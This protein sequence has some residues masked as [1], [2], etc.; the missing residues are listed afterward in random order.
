MTAP[1]SLKKHKIIHKLVHVEDV[2]DLLSKLL[3]SMSFIAA[4][5]LLAK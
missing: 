5:N 1:T 3:E 4:L 2:D